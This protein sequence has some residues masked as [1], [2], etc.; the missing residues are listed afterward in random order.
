MA[1]CFSIKDSMFKVINDDEVSLIECSS[2]LNKL[3]VPIIVKK[4]RKKYFITQIGQRAFYKSS[5]KHLAFHEDSELNEVGQEAFYQSK[6]QK[7][8][9]PPKISIFHPEALKTSS[10]IK[11][12]KNEHFVTNRGGSIYSRSSPVLFRFQNKEKKVVIRES[13]EKIFGCAF[14]FNELITKVFFPSSV[15]SIGKYAFY[16]CKNLV[17]VSFHSHSRLE[18]IEEFAF[19]FASVE[20]IVFPVSLKLIKMFAFH[21]CKLSEISF[22]E[23]SQLQDIEKHAFS[24]NP[25]K[26]IIFPQSVEYIR[27]F[28]FS[29]CK[30]LENVTFLKD[31]NMISIESCAFKHSGIKYINYPSNMT[32]L[33]K[34]DG[35]LRAVIQ[36]Y[37][38]K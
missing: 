29:N 32:K 37:G 28:A 35:K 22:K 7:I 36:D 17:S 2:N 6:I 23:N 16:R 33:L 31:S 21:S 18:T 15:V 9:F 1:R 11:F 14:C 4:R 19:S 27:N 8:V 3:K 5:I 34:M 10:R 20:K 38:D 25:V 26:E 30:S 12:I 13:I 24:S